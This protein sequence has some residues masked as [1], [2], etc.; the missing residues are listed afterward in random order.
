MATLFLTA[1]AQSTQREQV[2]CLDRETTIQ[3]KPPAAAAGLNRSWTAGLSRNCLRGGELF[4]LCRPLPAMKK[5]IAFL[6]DLCASAVR[7]P[8]RS[9]KAVSKKM[10]DS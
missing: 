1:E 2:F 10:P 8:F 3:A 4:F 7:N 9:F 6:C 5:K